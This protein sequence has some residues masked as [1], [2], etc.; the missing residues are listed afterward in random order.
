VHGSQ[1]IEKVELKSSEKASVD[2][3]SKKK[4]SVFLFA[5]FVYFFSSISYKPIAITFA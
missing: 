3:L 5:N 1:K 4:S 2:D